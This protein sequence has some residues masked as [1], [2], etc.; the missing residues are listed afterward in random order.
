VI[1]PVRF[2]D[3]CRL[4]KEKFPGAEFLVILPK[5]ARQIFSAE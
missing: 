5:N 2:S 3:F 4:L 1:S